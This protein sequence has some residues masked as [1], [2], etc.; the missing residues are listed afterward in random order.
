MDSNQ[1]YFSLNFFSIIYSLLCYAWKHFLWLF[2]CQFKLFSERGLISFFSGR[3]T[4]WNC[5]TVW[6]CPITVII[7]W[8]HG[9]S[10]LI[11]AFFGP[12]P[13][14][15]LMSNNPYPLSKERQKGQVKVFQGLGIKWQIGISA[16]RLIWFFYSLFPKRVWKRDP[17]GSSF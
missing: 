6:S 17:G 14:I 5:L 8:K 4:P 12:K 2:I 16:G 10:Q 9:D 7:S 13:S 15:L 3:K 11:I 1:L